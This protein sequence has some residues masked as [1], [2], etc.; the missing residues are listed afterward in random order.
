[1]NKNFKIIEAVEVHRNIYGEWTHPDLPDWEDY[2]SKEV[3]KEWKNKNFIELYY[4]YFEED[5]PE[6]LIK[7]YYEKD[8]TNLSKW[9]PKCD[10]E[11]SFLISLFD[12]EDGPVAIFAIE[13]KEREYIKKIKNF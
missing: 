11:N 7:A 6:Y 4:L 12:G 13:K 9:E 10:I 8:E 1:M 5:A 2:V 3:L